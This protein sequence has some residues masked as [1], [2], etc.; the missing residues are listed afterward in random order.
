MNLESRIKVIETVS[1]VFF[2]ISDRFNLELCASD[3]DAFSQYFINIDKKYDDAIDLVEDKY[4][5]KGIKFRLESVDFF[6]RD[7]RNNRNQRRLINDCLLLIKK[8][9]F[10]ERRTQ[11]LLSEFNFEYCKNDSLVAIAFM[12]GGMVILPLFK[13]S[14]RKYPEDIRRMEGY[15][16]N[17][18][19]YEENFREINDDVNVKI[20]HI[21]IYFT[22]RDPKFLPELKSTFL[23]RIKKFKFF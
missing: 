19:S 11:S 13:G 17:F 20:S 4:F 10:F 6:N 3:I 8:L 14:K 15:G 12:N 9:P 18:T 7:W 21:H 1:D 5:N 2:E 16:H 22:I 23:S